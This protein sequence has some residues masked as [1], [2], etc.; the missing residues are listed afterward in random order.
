MIIS[1]KVARILRIQGVK[2][3]P[4]DPLNP[5]LRLNGR[6]TKKVNYERVVVR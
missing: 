3:S 2:E 6:R 1:E 5:F 4:L